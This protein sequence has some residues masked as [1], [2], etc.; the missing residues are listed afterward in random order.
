MQRAVKR[1]NNIKCYKAMQENQRVILSAYSRTTFLVIY[2]CSY[3]GSMK[4][5]NFAMGAFDNAF[6]SGVLL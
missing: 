3:N 6:N 2:S 5:I 4:D 1:V